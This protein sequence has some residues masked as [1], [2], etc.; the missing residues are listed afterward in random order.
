ML[1]H[2][3]DK[4]SW[5]WSS[6]P[7][8]SIRLPDSERKHSTETLL[9]CHWTFSLLLV[10]WQCALH[11]YSWCL[12]CKPW[13]SWLSLLLCT[14]IHNNRTYMWQVPR[15]K[16]LSSCIAYEPFY[17][18]CLS[19]QISR[20]RRRVC[21]RDCYNAP[22]DNGC[23]WNWNTSNFINCVPSQIAVRKYVHTWV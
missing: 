19:M 15:L 4:A 6:I 23:G 9:S 16:S 8:V 21:L 2:G 22:V 20:V 3:T 13:S 5:S 10:Q 1:E 17:C 14:S 12:R 11:H 18:R 7:L